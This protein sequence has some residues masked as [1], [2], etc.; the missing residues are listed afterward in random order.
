MMHR[1]KET[2]KVNAQ[3]TSSHL[4]T[5]RG[6]QRVNECV[7][8]GLAI[9]QVRSMP[10]STYWQCNDQRGRRDDNTNTK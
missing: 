2:E 7:S 1:A 3:Q 5:G 4:D 8:D 6:M 9:V 10:I